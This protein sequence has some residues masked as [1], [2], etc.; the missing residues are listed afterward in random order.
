M[1]FGKITNEDVPMY[2]PQNQ[3]KRDLYLISKT[4]V[5]YQGPFKVDTT[6]P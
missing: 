4:C 6:I 5:R 1:C 3:H 2:I